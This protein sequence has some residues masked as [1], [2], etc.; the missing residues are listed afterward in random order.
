MP[1]PLAITP[2]LPAAVTEPAAPPTSTLAE[3]LTPA[4]RPFLSEREMLYLVGLAI[5]SVPLVI[6]IVRAILQKRQ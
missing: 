2:V 5:V 4:P 3:A 1:T 6:V